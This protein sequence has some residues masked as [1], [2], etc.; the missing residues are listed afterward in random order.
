MEVNDQKLVRFEVVNFKKI[1]EIRITVN[2]DVNIIGGE[3]RQGKTSIIDAIEV[4]LG[5]SKAIKATDTT[6]PVKNGAT[7]ALIN[8]ELTDFIIEKRFD[9][10]GK[11]NLFVR[12][13][14]GAA[15]NS[16]QSMLDSF[17]GS[18][19][20]PSE[21]YKMKSDQQY[22]VLMDMVGLEKVLKDLDE[23]YQL[24]YSERTIV[25]RDKTRLAKTLETMKKP[26]DNLPD[27]LL[28]AAEINQKLRD[29][30][31]IITNNKQNEIKLENVR[32]NFR[33][34][35]EKII[36]LEEEI[37]KL[38][39]KLEAEKLVK[40]GYADAGKELEKLVQNQF[41]PDVKI[42]ELELQELEETNRQI[43][44]RN[45]YSLIENQVGDL[46]IESDLLTEDLNQIQEEKKKTLSEAKFPV[47]GLSFQDNYVTYNGIPFHQ[48]S[49]EEKLS[50]SSI[51]AMTEIPN[52]PCKLKLLLVRDGSPFDDNQFAKLLEEIRIRGYQCLIERPGLAVKEAFIIENGKLKSN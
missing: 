8:L 15:Y 52:K 9:E 4:A 22:K 21:F 10:S 24:K 49:S 40:Q 17:I 37:K 45:E 44:H 20:D 16:P 2:E 27:D 38:Q 33:K 3:N 42:Y 12:T 39:N 18:F 19:V 41:V 23:K 35:K 43:R 7:E 30:N 14:N 11:A 1:D 46:A 36:E 13:K 31:E 29:A 50:I 32:E 26:A 48:C 51:I 25:N 28:S 6:H 5:G 47:E 34:S